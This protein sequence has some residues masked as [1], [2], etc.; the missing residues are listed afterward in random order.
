MSVLDFE[1]LSEVGV[2]AIWVSEGVALEANQAMFGD[3]Q[4]PFVGWDCESVLWLRVP[5][6]VEFEVVGNVKL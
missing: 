3:D 4:S 2:D 5:D 1:R 6:G